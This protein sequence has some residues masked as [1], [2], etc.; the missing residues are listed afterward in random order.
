LSGRT[1]PQNQPDNRFAFAFETGA[2][3]N[4]QNKTGKRLTTG[5]ALESVRR[6][7]KRAILL[8]LLLVLLLENPSKIEDEDE[9]DDEDE[10]V[11]RVFHTAA[12][13]MQWGW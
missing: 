10:P 4:R 3:G 5:T 9:N 1:D 2:L 7:P 8:V 11:R 13:E 12:R 6:T